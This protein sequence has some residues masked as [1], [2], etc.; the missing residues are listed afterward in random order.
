MTKLL[1]D[2]LVPGATA[3]PDA[4]LR[5]LV[6]DGALVPIGP[7]YHPV[8]APPTPSMRAAAIAPRIPPGLAS[9]RPVVA[10]TS[11]AWVW[12]LQPRLEEPLAIIAQGERRMPAGDPPGLRLHRVRLGEGDVVVLAGLHVTSPLRTAIDLLRAEEADPGPIGRFL[13][14]HRIEPGAV[15]ESLLGRRRLPGR[16][17]AL[18]RAQLLLTR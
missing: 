1:P 17:R 5:S 10:G 11:A 13:D 8:D 4:M 12:G 6:L 9:R 18:V 16:R 3:I 15:V 7:G 2:V 14:E